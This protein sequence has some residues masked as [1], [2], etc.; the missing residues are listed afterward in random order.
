MRH[1]GNATAALGTAALGTPLAASWCV[2]VR[3][4]ACAQA[5]AQGAFFAPPSSN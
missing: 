5:G 4:R 2:C 3:V 1:I